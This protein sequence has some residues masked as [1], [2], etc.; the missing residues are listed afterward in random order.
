MRKKRK[1]RGWGR[2]AATANTKFW[3]AATRTKVILGALSTINLTTG[4]WF[5]FARI[6]R[7]YVVI[8]PP[9]GS[10]WIATI[11]AAVDL[12]IARISPAQ[13]FW[14]NPS[15]TDCL[16]GKRRYA[17]MLKQ[18][19]SDARAAANILSVFDRVVSASQRGPSEGAARSL[20][21]ALLH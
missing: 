4:L 16:G 14:S 18:C 8:V 1:S 11:K 17:I 12:A 15:N 7:R 2:L 19:C 5:P 13:A 10:S 6:D 3:S 9:K 20:L 21:T